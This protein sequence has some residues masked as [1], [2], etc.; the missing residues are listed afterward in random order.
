MRGMPRP[1]PGDRGAG[2]YVAFLMLSVIVVFVVVGLA[3]GVWLTNLH[4]GLLALAFGLVGTYVS[5]E[6]PGHR[7][8]RLFLAT[9]AVEAVVFLGRQVGHTGEGTRGEQWWAWLGVWPVVIA[10]ALTTLSVIC[11]PDGRLPSPRWRPVVGVILGVTAIGA[12]LSALWPVEYD[13]AGVTTVHPVN[14]EA[15]DAVVTL[16]SAL[17]RP[18]YAGFQLLWIVAVAVR[19]RRA[20][21]MAR[22]PLAVLVAATAASAGALIAGLVVRGT[23]RPGI[24]AAA[25]VPLAMGWAVVHGQHLATYTALSWLSRAGPGAADLPTDLAHAVAETLDAP[26]AT[27][28]IGDDVLHAV[29]VWPETTGVVPPTTRAA[30]DEAHDRQVRPIAQDGQTVGALSVAR[31]RDHRLSL[32][33]QRL[34][35]DLA[36]QGRFVIEHVGLRETAADLATAR[37]DGRLSGLTPREREVLELMARGLS[38]RAICEELHLSVKTVEPAVSSI[39]GKLGLPVDRATNRRVLAVVAYLRT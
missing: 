9:G 30:L 6:R 27:L 15:P 11:F 1:E 31:A 2:G 22:A 33:E 32:T 3:R 23:P 37:D 26:A 20:G 29:G 7:L 4:N 34:F 13:Q 21:P 17:V 18:A 14:A 36:A 8:G 16:W 19:W 35:D 10:L 28:W 38:N 12:T 24:L 25:L 39:F 5:I